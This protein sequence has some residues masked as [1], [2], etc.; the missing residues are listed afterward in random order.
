[1]SKGRLTIP[2]DENFV[3]GTKKYVE[4]WCFSFVYVF[5]F[6]SLPQIMCI[7]ARNKTKP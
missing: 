6:V 5:F 4:K 1:M 2:T 7:I 3:E